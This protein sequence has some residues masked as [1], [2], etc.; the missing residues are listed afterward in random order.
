MSSS[1]IIKLD[2]TWVFL[3]GLAVTA[4]FII[5]K[6]LSPKNITSPV[7]EAGTVR[8][9]EI[10]TDV[11]GIIPED[12]NIVKT[13]KDERDL[14]AGA[15]TVN[16]PDNKSQNFNILV[17][18]IDRRYEGQQDWRSDVIQLITLSP[19][20]GKAVVTHIPRDVWAGSYK[21][22]AV[23]KLNGPDAMKDIVEEVTGQRP[24]RV[25][26]VDFD[27]FVWAVDGV[28]GVNVNVPTAFSDSGYPNDRKGSLETITVEFE[29]GPQVMDGETALIYARS[30]KGTNGE[31]SDY[32]RGTRQQLI[33]RAAAD[34]Y[35]NLDNIFKPKTAE[36]LFKIATQKMYTDISL[37]DTQILYEL[38]VNRDSIKI[39][40]LGLDTS[41]FLVSPSDRSPYGGQWVLTAKDGDYSPLHNEINSL[42]Q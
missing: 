6:V 9:D 42:L 26:R 33:M 4:Y 14:L 30:R 11:E 41:N 22:N 5:P 2:A 32:A 29:Q 1:L 34:A 24:D 39:S 20:R 16:N 3:L 18:G 35:F 31:G 13:E 15:K 19:D 23:Y 7:T 10:N 8:N 38:L 28:G 27:A 21:I 37:R 17:L 25:I 12:E 40:N 36:T